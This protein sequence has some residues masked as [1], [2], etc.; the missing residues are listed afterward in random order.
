MLGWNMLVTKVTVGGLLGY[1]SVKVSVRRNVPPSH[2]VSSGPK[3]TACHC[4]MLS[5]PGEALT[6]AGGSCWMRLKSRS[7]RRR[8]GVD[9]RGRRSGRDATER[10]QGQDEDGQPLVACAKSFPH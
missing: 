8:E 4:M 5:S 9:M 6:P 1:S 3:M 2:K 10:R 7:R